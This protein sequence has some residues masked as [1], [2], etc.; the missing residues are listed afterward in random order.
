MIYHFYMQ[1]T[2]RNGVEQGVVKDL[3]KDFKGLFYCSCDGLETVG[4]V[5]NIY[6]ESYVEQSGVRVYHPSDNNKVATYEATRV[7]LELFFSG[8]EARK[9]LHEFRRFV[10][11]SRVYFWDTARHKKVWLILQEESAPTE[12]S[13]KNDKFIRMTFT[14]SNIWGEGKNCDDKGILI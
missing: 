4:R 10:L 5:K 14:F 2:D 8:T 1:P 13:I 7:E 11:S 6:T 9:T 12:D 3:E